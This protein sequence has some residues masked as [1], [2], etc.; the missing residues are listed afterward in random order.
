MGLRQG[1]EEI[2]QGMEGFNERG[3]IEATNAFRVGEVIAENGSKSEEKQSN[4]L[5]C[6]PKE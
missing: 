1:W 5:A 4:P 3:S 6:F 2:A